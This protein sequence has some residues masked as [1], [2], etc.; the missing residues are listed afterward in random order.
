LSQTKGSLLQLAEIVK[1]SGVVDERDEYE[2]D[3]RLQTFMNSMNST[4]NY[5]SKS[6]KLKKFCNEK[7]IKVEADPMYMN[8]SRAFWTKPPGDQSPLA[9]TKELMGMPSQMQMN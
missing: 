3:E 8:D 4:Y 5:H 7:G 9:S 6:F 2:K 1:T